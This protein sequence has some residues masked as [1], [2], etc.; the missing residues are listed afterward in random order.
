MDYWP[1][2]KKFFLTSGSAC[3]DTEKGAMQRALIKAGINQAN[4][5]EISSVL[6]P[7]AVELV[8][9]DTKQIPHAAF[10]KCVFAHHKGM[11]GENISAGVGVAWMINKEGVRKAYVVE[12]SGYMDISEVKKEV[13]LSLVDL[14]EAENLQIVGIPGSQENLKLLGKREWVKHMAETGKKYE[15]FKDPEKDY[16]KYLKENADKYFRIAAAGV[17]KISD[18]FGY[19]AAALVYVL[20]LPV[21]ISNLISK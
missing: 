6:D 14:A 17:D 18:D 1:V 4:I 13:M 11:K 10:A 3:S 16:A 5:I 9:Y 20:E 19:A 12:A 8:N 15:G 7:D 21:K 2:A